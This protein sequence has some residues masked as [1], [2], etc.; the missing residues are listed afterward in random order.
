MIDQEK[1]R[2]EFREYLN[3]KKVTKPFT[4]EQ[5]KKVMDKLGYGDEMEE[6][7]FAL[8]DKE[9]KKC[10]NLKCV[11]NKLNLLGMSLEDTEERLEDAL[12]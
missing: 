8:E 11:V 3:E 4:V 7:W 1:I 10:N 5:L 12:N 2:A 9:F 6:L